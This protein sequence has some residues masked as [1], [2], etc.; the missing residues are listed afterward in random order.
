MSTQDNKDPIAKPDVHQADDHV[1]GSAKSTKALFSLDLLV[2]HE[3]FN[4]KGAPALPSMSI[5][6]GDGK[7]TASSADPLVKDQ[8][9]SNVVAWTP[10]VGRAPDAP[11][12][13]PHQF[14]PFKLPNGQMEN[15]GYVPDSAEDIAKING[16]RPW[17]LWQAE[18]SG[19]AASTKG[20]VTKWTSAPAAADTVPPGASHDDA[21]HGLVPAVGAHTDAVAPSV[22]PISDSATPSAPDQIII[23]SGAGSRAQLFNRGPRIEKSVTIPPA[24]APAE[25]PAQAPPGPSPDA[26]QIQPY[27][28]PGSRARL[29]REQPRN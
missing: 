24:A 21:S 6:N 16:E 22:Q 15:T 19:P 28:G 14:K 25:A 29:F 11:S 7:P 13:A 18:G 10:A 12:K 23:N 9:S 1:A 20:D 3:A 27:S 4:T 5:V 17:G 8:R 26:P 2:K